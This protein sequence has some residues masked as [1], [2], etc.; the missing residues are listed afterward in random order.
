VVGQ[1]PEL[2]NV[3]WRPRVDA[4]A[5][6]RAGRL[7]TLTA[8]THTLPFI[9][10]AIGLA[11]LKP[12]TAPISLALLLHAWAIPE[13]YAAR[14]AGV[15]RRAAPGRDASAGAERVA[16]GLL[17][18]LVGHEARELYARTGLLLEAGGLGTWLLGPAGALL[19][20]PGGRCVHCY[21]VK[22]SE[23]SLPVGDRVAH[24]LLALRTDECGF[25]TV[26]NRAFAGAAWRVRRRLKPPA[27]EALGAAI[28]R[29]RC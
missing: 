2:A 26:A 8:V 1:L 20:A 29:A 18:D 4:G 21:C 12:V 19:V 25:A 6:R 11:V 23:P 3:S 22:V 9:A 28:A 7:W 27:R 5:L 15:V 13:L 17:G 16:L 24:L 14:G 10:A